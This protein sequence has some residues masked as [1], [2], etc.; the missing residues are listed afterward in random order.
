M[1]VAAIPRQSRAR[2]LTVPM[3]YQQARGGVAVDR[4]VPKSCADALGGLTWAG[5]RF[6]DKREGAAPG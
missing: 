6:Q 5:I 1:S 3:S 4:E 2:L